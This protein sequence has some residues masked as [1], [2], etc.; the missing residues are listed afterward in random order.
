MSGIRSITV[1]GT[2]NV[3]FHLTRSLLESEIIIDGIWGR[4]PAAALALADTL[5]TEAIT[6]LESISSD[7]ALICISDDAIPE[8]LDQIPDYVKVAYTSGG[9]PMTALTSRDDLGVFYPLQT[10]SKDRFQEMFN[11]PFLIE[12][13]NPVFA[14]ELFDLAWKISK[15]VSFA[16]SEE[17]LHY[18]VAAVFVNNFTNHLFTIGKEYLDGHDLNW[19]YLRPLIQE[20]VRKIKTL[21]PEE[22]QTGPAVRGDEEI[23]ARHLNELS[24]SPREIYSL[25]TKSIQDIHTVK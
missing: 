15:N 22:A 16:S 14:Q 24:G 1:I 12:A 2:G 5:G 10:F 7:L 11:V 19:E 13:N 6:S 23:I 21:T 4:N 20:T 3:A 8:V 18:H 25:L 17:R 9:L